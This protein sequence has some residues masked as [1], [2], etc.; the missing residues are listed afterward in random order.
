MLTDW[1]HLTAITD[2]DVSH[3]QFNVPLLCVSVCV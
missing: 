3:V 1:Q 2:R